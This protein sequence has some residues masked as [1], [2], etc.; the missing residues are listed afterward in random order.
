MIDTVP[1]HVYVTLKTSIA[2]V[3]LL[4]SIHFNAY[5]VHKCIE[6]TFAFCLLLFSYCEHVK[7]T[8]QNELTPPIIATLCLHIKH[9]SKKI[10]N[11]SF[12][13]CHS[14]SGLVVVWM[15]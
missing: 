1:S 9:G 12:V 13:I 6:R 14:S 11:L 2:L 5:T 8:V 15:G 10:N 7:K 4:Y 3:S